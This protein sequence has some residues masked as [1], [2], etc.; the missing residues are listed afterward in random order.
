MIYGIFQCSVELQLLLLKMFSKWHC[1]LGLFKSSP[2]AIRGQAGAVIIHWCCTD[3]K[4]YKV[5]IF[6]QILCFNKVLSQLS[7]L[8]YLGAWG[9]L[10]KV[11]P[12]IQKPTKNWRIFFKTTRLENDDFDTID[13]QIVLEL[14]VDS[15]SVEEQEDSVSSETTVGATVSMQSSQKRFKATSHADIERLRLQC[16]NTEKTTDQQT[17]WAVSMLKGNIFSWNV[18]FNFHQ[19][20]HKNIY[21]T[22]HKCTA[23]GRYFSLVKVRTLSG[24]ILKNVSTNANSINCIKKISHP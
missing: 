6:Y 21:H 13:E 20:Q 8:E 23:W 24:L 14:F 2:C 18:V 12:K 4:S 17:K 15:F 7:I 3:R 22:E 11:F 5:F 16:S 10:V 19:G 1:L 9:S